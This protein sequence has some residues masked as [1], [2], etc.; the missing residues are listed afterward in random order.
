MKSLNQLIVIAAAMLFFACAGQKDQLV[1]IDTKHGQIVAVLFDDTPI[2]KSNFIDLAENGR[3]DSTEFHRIIPDF[4]VQGGDV[5]GKEDMPSEEWPTLEEEI[6]PEY[7]H[8]K[9]MIA[10][11]RQGNN[12]NPER[13]SSGSQFYIV[14]GKKY[15]ELEL[16]TDMPRLQAAF[17]QYIQV[18]SQEE[19]RNTYTRLY[20]A[21]EYDSLNQLLLS[22]RDEIEQSLSMNLTKDVPEERI[23]AYT[24]IGGTP[25]LDDE[26][27]VFGEVIRGIEVAE[28]IAQERRGPRDKPLDP[29]YMTVS[30]E[31]MSKGKIEKEFGYTYPNDN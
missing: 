15:T 2:H 23:D 31:R 29:V 11:A 30:V 22:K 10:A 19:L 26:Y 17:M 21:E 18:E 12:I 14:L 5:F 4:M 20:E 7:F 25:H 24:S 28:K 9:G 16:T 6:L 13:R 27:T 3:F 8:K 1:K